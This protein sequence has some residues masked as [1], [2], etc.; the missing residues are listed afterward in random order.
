[1]HAHP[2]TSCL[3][4]PPQVLQVE[5]EAPEDAIKAAYFQLSRQVHPD[6]VQGNSEG[7]TRAM[8]LVNDVSGAT[9]SSVGLN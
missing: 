5:A 2:L 6:K 8:Q 1:M 7:A 9:T 3:P 4:P